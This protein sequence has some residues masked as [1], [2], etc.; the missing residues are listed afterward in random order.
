[1]LLLFSLVFGIFFFILL[2]IILLRISASNNRVDVGTKMRP[3][4]DQRTVMAQPQRRRRTP[5]QVLDSIVRMVRPIGSTFVNLPQAIKMEQRMQQA[6]LPFRGADFLVLLGLVGILGFI[7]VGLLMQSMFMGLVGAFA[8][9]VG[10]LI[11]LQMVISNR[12]TAFGNQLG[13][14]LV[15]MSNALRAGFSFN[16]SI[17]LIGREMSSP[18]SDEFTKTVME[19]QLG[20]SAET[21]LD[22]MSRR[23]QSKDFDLV[24]TAVL[25]QRQVGG[26][27]SQILDTVAATIMERV[28]M[29]R[30]VKALTAQGRMSGYVL[31]GLPFAFAGLMSM[32]A[33]DFMRP[34]YTMTMGHI[35]IGI[36]L[37]LDF[38][39]LMVI[40]KLVNI[41]L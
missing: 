2:V 10:S 16:Q 18:I 35:M 34:M 14:A 1:M 37:F 7:I 8:A 36:G 9:I 4:L 38:I 41:E 23:V 12:R 22:N 28:R 5:G 17:A 11:W 39:G 13:D 21:A 24:V 30:E 20:A 32:I 25:I 19:M 31:V 33:P 26:N 6:D 15:M 3:Y 29:K 27:L 40:R